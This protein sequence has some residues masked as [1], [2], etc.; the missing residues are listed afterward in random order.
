MKEVVSEHSLFFILLKLI[1][2]NSKLFCI[3]NI[4]SADFNVIFLNA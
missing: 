2:S 1:Y 3:Y 4:E